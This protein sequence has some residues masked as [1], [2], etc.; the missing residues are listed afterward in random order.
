MTTT[1]PPEP[2]LVPATAPSTAAA[3]KMTLSREELHVDTEWRKTGRVRIRR[4]VTTRTHT[5]QVQLRREELTIEHLDSAG[6]SSTEEPQPRQHPLTIFLRE[7]VL[8]PPT[9]HTQAYEQIT[10][11]IDRITEQQ[12]IHADLRHEEVGTQHYTR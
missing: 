3:P 10:V 9:V 8:D 12:L 7:E 1:D 5:V 2:S 11:H 6:T 4:T